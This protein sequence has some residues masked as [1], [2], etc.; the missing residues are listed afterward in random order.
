MEGDA[1][2]TC[3]P[4]GKVKVKWLRIGLMKITVLPV[5]YARLPSCLV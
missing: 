1:L 2:Y 3:T 5:S 4:I